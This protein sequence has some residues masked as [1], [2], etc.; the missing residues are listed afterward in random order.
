MIVKGIKII[1]LGIADLKIYNKNHAEFIYKNFSLS[2]NYVDHVINNYKMC[3][4]TAIIY[5]E[6]RHSNADPKYV[7]INSNSICDREGWVTNGIRISTIAVMLASHQ[8]S[9]SC[10]YRK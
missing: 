7:T 10:S 2:L 5:A 1:N 9:T 3:N 8:F 4:K 6:V